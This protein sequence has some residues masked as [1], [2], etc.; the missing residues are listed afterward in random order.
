MSMRYLGF[1]LLFL[2]PGVLH[3]Q[4]A[5]FCPAPSLDGGYFVPEREQY[6]QGFKI[7][8]ACNEGRKPAVEGWWAEV[9]CE[10]GNWSPVPQCIE[11]TSCLQLPK[12]LHAKDTKGSDWYKQGR[13]VTITCDEGYEVLNGENTAVCSNGA[14][15]SVPICEISP[16]ACRAPPPIPHAVV[17]GLKYKEVFA[18]NSEVRYEC[19]DGYTVEGSESSKTITCSSGTWTEGPSC[20]DRTARDTGRGGSAG[21]G[22][23]GGQSSSTG[24]RTQPVGGGGRET[25]PST[26]RDEATAG[27]R[28]TGGGQSGSAAG[29]TAGGHSTSTSSITPASGGDSSGGHSRPAII[30]VNQ[31]GQYPVVTN[32]VLVETEPMYLKYQCSNFYKRVGPENVVCYS[33]GSWSERPHCEEDFCSVDAGQYTHFG[34]GRTGKLF[35]QKGQ[36]GTHIPC[37]WSY[38]TSLF[39]CI[40]G[41]I[42]YTQCCTDYYHKA[43]RCSTFSH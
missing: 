18:E 37:A 32:G 1:V 35:I 40:N 25:R 30:P 29:G 9:S 11:E 28:G 33:D 20:I 23:S 24:S 8:Y 5:V 42:T 21:V 6:S 7:I 3:A 10:G 34:E 13:S 19:E 14:W 22:T 16:D 27:G 15:T 38:Y 26:G 31:C 41:K 17:V 2:L 36:T 43:G 4:R 39:K 12:I